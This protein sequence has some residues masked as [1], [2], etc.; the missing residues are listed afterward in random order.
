MSVYLN[1]AL[2]LIATLG[3][4]VLLALVMQRLRG[5][6]PWRARTPTQLR[7]AVEE[8]C[9]VDGKRR[10]VLVRCGDQRLVLLTGGTADL[11]VCALPRGDT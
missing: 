3:G 2:M 10:L 8:A 9:M 4:I 5:G 6:V 7:L 11:V 1:A